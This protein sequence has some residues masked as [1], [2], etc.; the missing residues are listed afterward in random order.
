MIVEMTVVHD[1]GTWEIVPLLP[2]KTAI[3]CFWMCT[4]KMS[5]D[6]E[7]D[8]LKTRLV[9]K[10]YTLI[11][12]FD[13]G[14]TFSLVTKIASVY[15]LISMTAMFHWSLYQLD[16]KNAFLH[17]ELVEE[18]YMEQPPCSEGVWV[19]VSPADLCMVPRND[20]GHGLDI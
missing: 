5:A 17:G 4:V 2:G 9:T 15:L 19:I 11:D 20:Q 8:P 16:V 1:N 7:V 6:G 10:R 18:V 3:G 14:D 13:N 12:G